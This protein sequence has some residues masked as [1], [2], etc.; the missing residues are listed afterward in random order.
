M[1]EMRPGDEIKDVDR[2]PDQECF[3][4]LI[5]RKKS[6]NTYGGGDSSLEYIEQI[7]FFTQEQVAKWVK[8]HL[9]DGNLKYRVIR[10]VPVIIETTIT[11]TVR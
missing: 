9:K 10:S 8:E 5:N 6:F 4:I 3:I 11:V 2:Y 1:R 7:V